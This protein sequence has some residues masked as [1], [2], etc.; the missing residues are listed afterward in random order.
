[1][2]AKTARRAQPHAQPKPK[3]AAADPKPT[4][5]PNRQQQVDKSRIIPLPTILERK[6]K[7][8]PTLNDHVER[9]HVALY[10]KSD[11]YRKFL[12]AVYDDDAV[13]GSLRADNLELA[14]LIRDYAAENGMTEVVKKPDGGQRT[15]E[16]IV[17]AL[18]VVLR[19]YGIAREIRRNTIGGEYVG[20]GNS[21]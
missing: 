8:G 7:F 17:K 3:P 14:R 21:D 12:S 16:S 15:K 19:R 9:I 18:N 13:E 10:A 11:E 1:M 20:T 5:K 4:A 6:I 2:V